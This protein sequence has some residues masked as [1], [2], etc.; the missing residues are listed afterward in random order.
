MSLVYYIGLN[1]DPVTRKN[2]RFS[3]N[4]K[5]YEE[6]APKYGIN[7]DFAIYNEIDEGHP[8][9]IGVNTVSGNILT[10]SGKRY[11][12]WLDWDKS[13]Q[14]PIFDLFKEDT[15]GYGINSDEYKAA[16][17]ALGIE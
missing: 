6:L 3:I 7:E 17:K 14:E 5:V 10:K 2:E 8:L 4:V 1:L 13:K 15:T 16:K 11:S 12:F 9:P